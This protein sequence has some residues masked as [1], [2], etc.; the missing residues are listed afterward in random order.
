M[1]CRHCGLAW[2]VDTLLWTLSE[3]CPGCKAGKGEEEGRQLARYKELYMMLTVKGEAE[4]C[5][6]QMEGVYSER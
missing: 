1:Q 6:G 5:V 2:P 3:S 4:W